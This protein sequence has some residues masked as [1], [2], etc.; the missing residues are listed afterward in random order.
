MSGPRPLRRAPPTRWGPPQAQAA[1]HTGSAPR[2]HVSLSLA[3]LGVTTE[4]LPS[5]HVHLQK[6]CGLP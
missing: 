2:P 1:S 4:E 6:A 3:Q 5:L